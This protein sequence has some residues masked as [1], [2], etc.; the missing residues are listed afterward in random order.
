MRVRGNPGLAADTWVVALTG[1]LLWPQHR[2]GYGLGHGMPD[3]GQ[4]LAHRDIPRF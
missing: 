4:R 3:L 2:F 1:V